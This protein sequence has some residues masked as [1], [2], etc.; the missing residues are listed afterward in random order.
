MPREYPGYHDLDERL[1]EFRTEILTRM[2]RES[3]LASLPRFDRVNLAAE[4]GSVVTVD[5]FLGT[6]NTDQVSDVYFR[7]LDATSGKCELGALGFEVEDPM[8]PTLQ[9][10]QERFPLAEIAGKG[11]D[12]ERAVRIRDWIKSLFPHYVPYRMPVWNALTILDRASRGVENFLCI[13]YSVSLVQSCLALGMQARMINIHRGIADNYVVGDEAT[14]DPP[15]DEHVVVEVWSSEL[16]SWFMLDTDFDCH[17]ERAGIP[18]SAWEIHQAFVTGELDQLI[19]RRGPDSHAFTALGGVIDS[20]DDFF[21][22]E[23][24]SYYAHVSVLMRNDFLSDPEG[25]V[26]VAH[27]TDAST[28]AVIWH[29][30]SDLRLQPHLMGPVVVANPYSDEVMLLTD[31][32]D[33]TGWASADS[34]TGHWVQISLPGDRMVGRIAFAWPEHSAVYRTSRRLRV[35]AEVD[36]GWVQLAEIEIDPE[37]PFTLHDLPATWTRRIRVVQPVNGGHLLHPDRLWLT[38]VELFGPPAD[39]RY[40]ER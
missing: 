27:L 16:G 8:H 10:L 34:T 12:V 30:G 14:A 24:P 19:C 1:V 6:V 26:Q 31:G 15:I 37:G 32:N 40:S 4:A 18:L 11:T 28:A 17:Y 20:E 33:R 35:E 39:D 3:E 23:L 25:P 21:G 7:V 5:S 29:R 22:Y 2:R 38:Q 13:H 36:G 9:A